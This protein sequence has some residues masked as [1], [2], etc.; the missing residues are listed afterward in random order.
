MMTQIHHVAICW[1]FIEKPNAVIPVEPL[2]VLRVL[3]NVPLLLGETFNLRSDNGN[4]A[5]V[6]PERHSH[7]SMSFK[8]C[9][10]L[11]P[12]VFKTTKQ[13]RP[14]TMIPP[15]V[16]QSELEV[17]PRIDVD[18]VQISISPTT[19]H[20]CL[21]ALSPFETGSDRSIGASRPTASPQR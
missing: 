11:V 17:V 18:D 19:F 3:W 6:L 5:V 21:R 9:S 7:G 8:S 13:E 16:S 12:M 20:D 15:E 2:Q 1:Q 4:E 10:Q 14:T